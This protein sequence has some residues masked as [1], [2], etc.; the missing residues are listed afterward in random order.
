MAEIL[1]TIKRLFANR[2]TGSIASWEEVGPGHL[3]KKYTF[4]KPLPFSDSKPPHSIQPILENF[5]ALHL[6]RLQQYCTEKEFAVIKDASLFA[7]NPLTVLIDN[8][9]FLPYSGNHQTFD[10]NT[11]PAFKT[12]GY[13][14]KT[15][16]RGKTLVLATSGAENNFFYWTVV[17]MQKIGFIEQAGMSLS[18]FEHILIN[19]IKY[20]YQ[21]QLNQLF[22]L[23]AYTLT[24]IN[25]GT[26]YHC[27]EMLVFPHARD[28]YWGYRFVRETILK[29]THLK[30]DNPKRIYIR[31]GKNSQG[32][33]I[34][35]EESVLFLLK[36]YGFY[37]VFLE[38]FSIVEQASLLSSAEVV[39]APHGA[40]LVNLLFASPNTKV[41]ELIN[42]ESINVVY[43]L[44]SIFNQ[45]NYGYLLCQT[46]I[47]EGV[48]AHNKN[49]VIEVQQLEELFNKMNITKP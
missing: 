46:A 24:E 47:Q 35:N 13:K 1:H 12:N 17:L 30:K 9:V 28:N 40:G 22:G 8:K 36:Q 45:L 15:K 38:D 10:S 23:D 3:L 26:N 48:S 21:E 19:P 16:L 18:D 2:P 4:S 7:S 25:Y 31:R 39:V 41:I 6:E 43:Y 32:R 49:L 44:H 5:A 20:P 14:K 27:Q 33:N 29:Q 37:P 42:A 34:Q 11:H